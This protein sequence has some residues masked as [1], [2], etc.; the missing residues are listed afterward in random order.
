MFI[1]FDLQL[2][3]DIFYHIM[4]SF[5]TRGHAFLEQEIRVILAELALALEHVHKEGY[6]H[7]DVKAENVM[8]DSAGHI[9]LIDFGLTLKLADDEEMAM[10]PTG[11]LVYMAPELIGQQAGGRHTDWWAV[12]VLCF[13]MLTGSSPWPSH[14]DDN[15]VGHHIRSSVVVCP[16]GASPTMSKFIN[17][18]L[19]KDHKKRLGSRSDAD[20]K[21]APFFSTIDW[22]MTALGETPPAFL[23][24]SR[25]VSP[26]E[27][28]DAMQNYRKYQM[29]L[30]VSLS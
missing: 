1:V 2:G 18:L 23:L 29:P 28:A 4:E 14:R 15:L 5:Q 3:G 12:G 9:K 11:S 25:C 27:V 17:S 8:L 13:E 16:P 10:S 24:K 6:I 22:E 21:A 30:A 26:D 19:E 20:I 7:R